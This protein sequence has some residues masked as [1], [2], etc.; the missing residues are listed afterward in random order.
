MKEVA[1]QVLSSLALVIVVLVVMW[2]LPK[3]KESSLAWAPSLSLMSAW[4]GLL[5]VI[6]TI[7]LWWTR[8]PDA[9]LPPLLLVLL[10]G[11]I[12]SGTLVLWLYRGFEGD[13]ELTQSAQMQTLQARIGIALGLIATAI[14]YT[15]VLAHKAP[16][17]PVGQ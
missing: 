14:G 11:A 5:G 2:K 17:T 6:G 1:L 15:F 16:L 8:E 13:A 4:C 9:W 10:P 12:A 7:Y 3:A